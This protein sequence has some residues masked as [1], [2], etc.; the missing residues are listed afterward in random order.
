MD[1]LEAFAQYLRAHDKSDLTIR[2]YTRDVRLFTRWF[3]QRTG[4]ELQP[5]LVTPLDVRAYRDWLLARGF[6]PN[7]CARKLAALSAF[8]RWAKEAGLVR[9]DPTA[10][11][12][13]P[14]QVT[15]AP[16]WLTKSQRHA[17][18]REV[19]KAVQLGELKAGGDASQICLWR[20][21]RDLAVIV[22]LL[23]AGLR[24]REMSALTLSDVEIGR[25]AGQVRVFGKGSKE[26]V[27]PLNAEARKAL[28]DWLQIR[29]KVKTDALFVTQLGTPLSARSVQGIVEKYAR[30]AG[31]EGVTAHTLRHTFGKGL[32]DAG[33]PLDRV[34]MLMG[35]SSINT[36]RIYTTPSQADLAE[37]V[38]RLK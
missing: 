31:L 6:S 25:R 5:E 19:Q 37:A 10:E 16:K 20:P 15:L 9:F 30:R 21:R 7:T 27:I 4:E 32:V 17:L 29:P 24:V 22:L 1:H 12:R 23:N 36:T 35:H 2:A 11:I 3:R 26:R 28:A 33:V 18:L 13:R 8:F 38:E 34:A 14:R